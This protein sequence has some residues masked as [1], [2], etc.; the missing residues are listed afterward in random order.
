MLANSFHIVQ[1]NK[2]T[3]YIQLNTIHEKSNP[4]SANN[5]K[6]FEG[7]FVQNDRFYNE[8]VRSEDDSVFECCSLQS[9][10][11]PRNER[12]TFH[13][14]T[15]VA[16]LRASFQDERIALVTV[17]YRTAGDGVTVYG[18]HSRQACMPSNVVWS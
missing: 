2:Q 5:I 8:S 6:S 9:I 3:T 13:R 10:S 16:F 15:A 18:L 12:Q 7:I 4:S 11:F 1:D 14:R 17:F